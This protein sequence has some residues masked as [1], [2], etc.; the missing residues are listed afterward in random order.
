MIA[1]VF[2]AGLKTSVELPADA[3]HGDR[4]GVVPVVDGG[5]NAR[6]NTVVR[7]QQHRV[8]VGRAFLIAVGDVGDDVHLD[9]VRRAPP[10]GD[11]S[12]LHVLV[13]EMV[14]DAPARVCRAEHAAQAHAADRRMRVGG[15]RNPGR[16]R[17][18]GVACGPG[19]SVRAGRDA[20]AAGAERAR[21]VY[22]LVVQDVEVAVLLL[23]RRRNPNHQLVVDDREIVR[24]AHVHAVA[25]AGLKLDEPFARTLRLFGDD[26]HRAP[27]RVLAEQ[28]ALRTAQHLHALDVEQIEDRALGTAV[29]DVVDV[30]RHAGLERQRV[31]AQADAADERRRGRAP[32]GTERRNHGVRHECVEIECARGA[33]RLQRVARD[34]GD[35]ERRLL[36]VLLA[37]ACGNED[38]LEPCLLGM[39]QGGE[40]ASAEHR[41]DREPQELWFAGGRPPV[42]ARCAPGRE[43]SHESPLSET[44]RTRSQGSS[45]GST[46]VGPN[47]SS[48]GSDRIAGFGIV[49]GTYGPKKTRR[50]AIDYRV[51]RPRTRIGHARR[52]RGDPVRGRAAIP[53]RIY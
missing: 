53:A 49:G 50:T 4:D 17:G 12:R 37:E 24:A 43:Y 1:R 44:I 23:R 52:G 40:G 29:I 47:G 42:P 27:E 41:R 19:H 33:A 16:T 22:A 32:P 25:L 8:L 45:I 5:A 3:E 34:R 39:N 10:H 35:R 21:A 30:D 31:V 14:H 18:I 51:Q 15:V 48:G 2:V 13:A 28:R 9:L 38:F 6:R 20:D 46:M 11:A 7:A 36:Q 26:A